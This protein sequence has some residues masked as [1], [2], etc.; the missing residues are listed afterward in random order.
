MLQHYFF[1]VFVLSLTDVPEKVC[2]PTCSSKSRP[3]FILM[4]NLKVLKLAESRLNG[5]SGSSPLRRLYP[6]ERPSSPWSLLLLSPSGAFLELFP[7]THQLKFC[8]SRVSLP[9]CRTAS[10]CASAARK[11][12]TSDSTPDFW[13]FKLRNKLFTTR[14]CCTHLL[15]RYS[16]R[17]AHCAFADIFFD[18]D[19][20]TRSVG[21]WLDTERD[22]RPSYSRTLQQVI[23]YVVRKTSWQPLRADQARHMLNFASSSE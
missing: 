6:T 12:L 8:A 19:Q 14:V 22:A 4:L 23:E 10:S 18:F 13:M 16:S 15:N 11:D 3:C 20:D 2:R 9:R 21:F 5:S 1:L 17:F 7:P